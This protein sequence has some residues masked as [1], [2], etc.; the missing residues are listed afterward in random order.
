[1]TYSGPIEAQQHLMLTEDGVKKQWE[2]RIGRTPLVDLSS[3][4]PAG[5]GSRL[6]AKLESANPTGSLKD[7]AVWRMLNEAIM[8]RR[9]GKRRLLDSSSGNAAIA[10]AAIG[11]SLGIPVT[12]VVP[13]NASP[14]RLD[15]I[16][17]HG[18]ELVLTDPLEGY[19]FAIAE[20]RRLASEHPNRY[21]YC[22]QYEN[23]QNWR[24]HYDGTGAEIEK[25]LIRTHFPDVLVC[26]VGTGGSLTGIGRRLREINPDLRIVAVIPE[27]F[28]GIEG[29]KP[30]GSPED[31]VP[32]ILDLSL[33]DERFP[34]SS[35]EAAASCRAL[36]RA[37]YFVGPSSGACVH[38]AQCCAQIKKPLSIVTLLYDTG[39][40]YLSTGLWRDENSRPADA[41]P[42]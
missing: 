25:A 19:D 38:V 24:A 20:A 27:V 15:R 3:L 37:G 13:G 40:R 7:R 28:P 17:A 2:R 31:F 39:E 26:G 9:I 11:A 12:L 4:L 21:W 18:A 23:P 30:L 29:L 42:A 33:V 1:M 5:S 34:V 8:H 41:P 10:Y 22:N 14:E 16:R 36:A 35:E 6:Y 32:P